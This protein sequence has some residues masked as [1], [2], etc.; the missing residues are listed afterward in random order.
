MTEFVV[1]ASALMIPLFILIPLFGKLMDLGFQSELAARYVTWERTIW[2]RK[3]DQPA[4]VATYAARS[5]AE[6]A[7]TAE[8]RFFQRE[9]VLIEQQD[10]V[11]SWDPAM[12]NPVWN[13]ALS[14]GSLFAG[15]DG[16]GGSLQEQD[17]PAAAYDV[18]NGYNSVINIIFTPFN[19][20]NITDPEFAR[21]NHSVEGYYTPTL[22]T[23][24]QQ[25]AQQLKSFE[26]WIAEDADGSASG[27]PG[28]IRYGGAILA[29]GWNAADDNH[30]RNRADD[31]V[32][33]EFFDN[34]VFNTVI[35]VLSYEILPGRAIEPALNNLEWKYIGTK[36]IENRQVRCNDGFCQFQ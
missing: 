14:A 32:L 6:I 30:F 16:G 26:R 34:A 3:N 31:F 2:F 11:T 23:S 9:G 4:G 25:D 10:P 20:L 12:R 24:L 21:I 5:D 17:T 13:Y 8:R 22:A 33:S 18:I 1:S 35:N 27:L 19:V 7:R 36:P 15:S 28:A 29:D